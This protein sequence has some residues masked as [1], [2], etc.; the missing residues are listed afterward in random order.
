M[1][2]EEINRNHNKLM[3]SVNRATEDINK[4]SSYLERV[5]LGGASLGED[6][7]FITYNIDN[8]REPS[9]QDNILLTQL[10]IK[11]IKLDHGR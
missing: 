3:D 4:A 9:I 5:Q 6:I 8:T 11:K 2:V 7:E 10:M 1:D